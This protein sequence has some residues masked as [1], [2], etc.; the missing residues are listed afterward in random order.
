MERY[1]RDLNR[2]MAEI[3]VKPYMRTFT[4]SHLTPETE[5]IFCIDVR[6][7]TFLSRF[8]SL[9][10]GHFVAVDCTYITTRHRE[11]AQP[12]IRSLA[13]HV[14]AGVVAAM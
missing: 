14:L 10:R 9:H 3:L 13:F 4:A 11:Y 7:A 6:Q 2:T 5:Y 12:L 1:N 8:H